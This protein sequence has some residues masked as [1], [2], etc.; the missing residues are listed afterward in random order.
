MPI[1]PIE[2]RIEGTDAGAQQ[3]LSRTQQA[4]G[5]LNR[6]LQVTGNLFRSQF[7]AQM[8]VQALRAATDNVDSLAQSLGGLDAETARFSGS[9]ANM[10]VSAAISP[11]LALGQ[12]V[13]LLSSN[14]SAVAIAYRQVADAQ[15]G[16]GSEDQ[17]LF[18]AMFNFQIK[19]EGQRGAAQAS[20]AAWH[21][22]AEKR[23][24][25]AIREQKLK[26]ESPQDRILRMQQEFE[27]FRA[28]KGSNYKPSAKEIELAESLMYEKLA[29]DIEAV[30]QADAQRERDKQQAM[31]KTARLAQ[32]E[33]EKKKRAE[34]ELQRTI[35]EWE[36]DNLR[37]YEDGQK[38]RQR[39]EL[40]RIEAG[41]RAELKRQQ[42]LES[43]AS[44]RAA[45]AEA[46]AQQFEAGAADAKAWAKLPPGEALR[47]RREQRRAAR[48]EQL[49]E[50]AL[51]KR[52]GGAMEKA[53]HGGNLSSREVEALEFAAARQRAQSARADAVQAKADEAAAAK[54]IAAIK[55]QLETL[56]SAVTALLGI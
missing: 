34:D 22:E 6:E 20:R 29:K 28:G 40:K 18:G 10:G 3:A 53:E 27:D 26:N 56:S 5:G 7:S 8:F 55:T 44:Q 9:L 12:A 45:K 11:M 35:R 23:L 46:N 41:A 30:E 54:N 19:T 2:L 37:D 14:L 52:I 16:I 33:Q 17:G 13:G 1:A 39:A 32:Q 38:D 42:D 4:V 25:D 47:R 50:R 31:E 36:Q 48:R 21:G 15:K 51:E 24:Q 43:D 49:D